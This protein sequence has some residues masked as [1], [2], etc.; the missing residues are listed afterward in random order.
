[1][2]VSER[3][4]VE[5]AMDGPSAGLIGQFVLLTVLATTV[6][7]GVVGWLTGAVYGVALWF[8]LRRAL[9]R[10]GARTFGP[11]NQVTLARATLVGGVAA[12]T[13][14]SVSGPAP[15]AVLVGLAAVALALDGV[16][17]QVAR[18]T[19][20][21]S[22]LGARFDM[23]IDAVLIL[24]LSVV[25]SASLGWWALAIG[26]LRYAFVAA[27]WGLPWLR[28]SLPPRFSRKTVAAAQGIVL[29][30]ASADV[31]PR[32]IAAAAVGAALASLVWSF[33]SDIVWLWRAR[34]R[35]V[36]VQ[37]ALAVEIVGAPG[38]AAMLPAAHRRHAYRGT[39]ST[40]SAGRRGRTPGDLGC[41]ACGRDTADASARCGH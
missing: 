17:G 8:L 36:V 15:V 30:V 11:A 14:S 1:V 3:P 32:W 2:S 23:E 10:S 18:R 12:L 28:A 24:V 38:L 21:T 37:P 6:G 26:A 16:D 5:L 19:G 35:A 33:G 40:R 25:V 4:T 9:R 31:L 13:A 29:V 7:L 34:P 41:R 22:P 39:R 20:T 27:A